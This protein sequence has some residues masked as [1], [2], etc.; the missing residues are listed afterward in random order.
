[1]GGRVVQGRVAASM[2]K[3]DSTLGIWSEVAPMPFARIG[4]AAC[5][6]GSAI[7]TFGGAAAG[8]ARSDSVFRYDTETNTWSTLPKMPHRA[9]CHSANVLCGKVYNVGVGKAG[10]KVLR[11]DPVS[12][13]WST[14]MKT[15]HDKEGS[16]T[17]VL[18]G[19]LYAA[20]GP[21][22]SSGVECYDVPSNT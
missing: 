12:G 17:Y 3:F 14:M 16:A 7:F 18:R 19:C 21:H 2:L 1:M 20:G 13:V 8:G 6:I 9:H 22:Q 15:L 11:F 10:R 4:V 5:A